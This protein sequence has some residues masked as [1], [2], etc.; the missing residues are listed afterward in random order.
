VREFGTITADMSAGSQAMPLAEVL[1]AFSYALD[2]TEGQPEG[3][4]VR[5]S[6]IAGNIGREIGLTGHDLAELHYT[7][8]L[9][10]LGCSSNSARLSELYRADDRSFKHDFKTMGASLPGALRFLFTHVGRR[11]PI[12]KRVSAIANVLKNAGTIADEMIVTRCTRGADIARQLRF[13]EDVADGIYALDELW[14]G[15]GRPRKL[16][17]EAIP[18]FARIALLSQVAEVF[19]ARGGAV[20]ARAEI[21]KRSGRWFDPALVRAFL[22][23]S[24]RPEFWADLASP[25]IE[26]KV[27]A[28]SFDG[29]IIFV[30]EDY[31]DDIAA[32][33]GE[34][35]DAK[36][37]YTG[38][39]S[40]RVA[41][42]ASAVA[43]RIGFDPARLRWLRRGA[44]L[45]DIGKLS[46]SN[47]I[48][49]KPAGLDDEEWVTMRG[50]AGHTQAI[51]SRLSAFSDLAPIAAAHH[52]R[53]DGTG[54]PLG[55]SGDAICQATRIITIADFFDALVAE[56]PYRGA[57]PVER[58]LAIIGAEVGKAIDP[59]CFAALSAL[60]AEGLGTTA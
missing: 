60:A 12:G 48:L 11:E 4:C 31:L 23:V 6:W 10:D 36:S 24:K 56:R 33:F 16:A 37:P 9:K 30:D 7:A 42:Y 21:K 51:L 39:H 59:D 54:Y 55:L 8:L 26:A 1:A 19:H 25:M 28:L 2:I 27:L 45:H 53:L 14:D 18:L 32:A 47:A 3:H 22:T 35:V 49:D 29:D 38:G 50:H 43:A 44:L 46:V 40:Q 20:A 17:G 5:A 57:M 58:A 41:D 13:S 15:T 52:E 34:V